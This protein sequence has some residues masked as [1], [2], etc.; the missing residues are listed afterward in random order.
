LDD[1]S[2]RTARPISEGGRVRLTLGSGSA[3]RAGETG[4]GVRVAVLTWLATWV[5]GQALFS[6]VLAASGERDTD[7]LSLPTLALGIAVT[8]VAYLTGLWIASN[9]VGSG[10]FVDDY[11]LRAA[12][13]DVV[14]VPI[15]ILTQL[16]LVPLVYLPLRELWP[17]TFTDDRLQETAKD[18]ADRASGAAVLLLVLMVGIGA[19][20]VEELVYRGLLQGSLAARF[21]GVVAWLVVAS[22][23]TLIHFRP[24]EYPGLFVFA[25]VAGACALLTGRLGMSIATHMAFNVTGLVLAYG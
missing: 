1:V 7:A 14:G 17:D 24:V 13:I 21:S 5:A 25:L 9:R 18:L 23:F 8:W 16:V 4:I 11:Q 3:W 22:W 6:V 2:A 20:I 15:G 19:P 12:P 10:R